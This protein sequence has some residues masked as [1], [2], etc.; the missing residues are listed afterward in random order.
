MTKE[1]GFLPSENEL[2][3][4]MDD[5]S[6]IL[7]SLFIPT[8]PMPVRIE[9]FPPVPLDGIGAKGL[10][11][12]WRQILRNSTRLDS[13]QMSGHMD[14]A[15]HPF[16]VMTQTLVS[17][18][19]QNML[20]RELSPLASLV[21]EDLIDLF[22]THLKLGP[23]WDGTWASGGSIA[24]LTALFC[25]IGGYRGTIDRGNVHMFFPESGHASLKKAA[26]ILGVPVGQVHFVKCDDA[27]R[28]DVDE[29]SAALK[30]APRQA[31]NV[32]T[33][34]LGTTI[35]GS[36]DRIEEIAKICSKYGAWHHVDAIYGGAL[37]FSKTHDHFLAGLSS[38]DSIVIGPQKWMYVPRVSAAVL[39]SGRKRFDENLG[40]VMP[41]S[42]SG[43]V[44]RGVWGVQGSRPA[45]AMVL[46]ALLHAIG[47]KAVGE[48]IDR[49]IKLTRSFYEI[50]SNSSIL[51]PTHVPGLNLQVIR[52]NTTKRDTIE[53]QQRLKDDGS[54]WAS[55]SQW[56]DEKLLRTV[57]LS[58]KL[59]E[60]S[61]ND[62]VVSLE[63]AAS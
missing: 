12:L 6:S 46:W 51:S 59:N 47:T 36:I 38:A 53:I 16:A 8:T 15:P 4:L 57:L 22:K 26:L 55:V 60:D 61:L 27:G 14:T 40:V 34:V 29:L 49:S 3:V 1:T 43:E 21:E 42:I 23:D 32:V 18:L 20:F 17:A 48:Q 31:H 56:R 10:S 44:H 58:P 7:G 2:G 54:L 19:N 35:H 37:M 5:L 24:N 39:V 41:Y 50:L 9:D 63:R 28:I 25:A 52:P 30:K 13:P 62:F 11:V 33:S 45:D